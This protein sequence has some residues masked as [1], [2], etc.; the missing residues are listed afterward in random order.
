MD[1]QP[2][3]KPYGDIVIKTGEYQKDG[4]TKNRYKNIG[5][6]FATPHFSRISIKLDA[7]PNG[8]DG[9][10]SVFPREKSENTN[11]DSYDGEPISLADQPF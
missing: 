11:N 1:D 9:W 4:K 8:G 2:K 7:L 3:L 5:T 6:L 10:L